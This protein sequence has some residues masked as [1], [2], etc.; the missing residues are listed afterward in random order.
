MVHDGSD[1]NQWNYVAAKEN[2]VDDASRGLS[3]T[4]LLLNER[5]IHGPEVLWKQA[6]TWPPD[7]NISKIAEDDIE[8]KR[9]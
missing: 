9:F 2:P 7:E 8:V 4:D 1:P 5:W 6:N 3:A